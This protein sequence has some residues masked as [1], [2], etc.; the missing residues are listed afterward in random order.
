MHGESAGL[1]AFLAFAAAP[2]SGADLVLEAASG[3]IVEADVNGVPLRLKVELDHG[4]GI[5]LN[6]AAAARLALGRGDGRHVETIGP[7]KL[8]GRFAE[9]VVRFAG[10]AVKASLRWHDRDVAAGADGTVSPHVLP[11]DTVTLRRRVSSA[12]EREVAFSTRF[13]WNHGI[14]VPVP[15][16]RYRISA[17]FSL[18]RPR[19]TAPAAAAAAI[20]GHQG[21]ALGEERGMEDISAGVLRPVRPL[22]LER[23]LRVGGFEISR[24]M[25]RPS[26][27]RGKHSLAVP[28]TA[29]RGGEIVVTGQR[30]GQEA[31]Y[32]VT[33]GLDVLGGCSEAVYSRHAGRLSFRCAVG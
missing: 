29:A 24:L 9:R 21:G 32:R 6:P 16:G 26:D 30:P 25:A 18:D 19:T 1:L 10:G 22:R 20:S 2:A 13:H 28:G 15:V 4:E 33:I 3:H 7:V 8:R 11:F 23:P 27:W 14:H 31:L 17:R 12:G 5:D